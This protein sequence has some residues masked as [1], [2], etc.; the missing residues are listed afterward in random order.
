M[1]G[2]SEKKK[3]FIL[4]PKSGSG[5]LEGLQRKVQLNFRMTQRVMERKI[6]CITLRDRKT[7][8]WVREQMGIKDILVEI[9]KKK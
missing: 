1:L 5:M 3:T 4:K 8:E 7:T 9:K 6:N 2:E